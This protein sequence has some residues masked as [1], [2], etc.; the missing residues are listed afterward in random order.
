MVR[1]EKGQSI[2]EYITVFTAI[3]A[4]VLVLAYGPIRGAINNII[5]NATTS[6]GN[7]ATTFGANN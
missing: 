3:V 5:T 7:H 1:R 6:I 4:A 2:L